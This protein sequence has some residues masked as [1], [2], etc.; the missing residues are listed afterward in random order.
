MKLWVNQKCIVI[1]KYLKLKLKLNWNEMKWN[2]KYTISIDKYL[3]I[4]KKFVIHNYN[5]NNEIQQ[6]ELIEI[7]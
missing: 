5:N 3:L 2:E 1:I 4:Y 6:W 7:L